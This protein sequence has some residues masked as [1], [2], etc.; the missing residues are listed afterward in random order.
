MHDSIIFEFECEENLKLEKFYYLINIFNLS[1][2]ITRFLLNLC[3][4]NNIHLTMG[5][6]QGQYKKKV[7]KIVAKGGG[8][9]Q[10]Q[11]RWV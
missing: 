8:K 11:A 2:L 5:R 3:V 7:K 9:K 4:S 6:C 1:A 10:R